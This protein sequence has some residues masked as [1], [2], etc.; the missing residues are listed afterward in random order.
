MGNAEAPAIA[1]YTLLREVGRGGMAVVWQA[2]QDSL[3][4][5]VALK[6]MSQDLAR[7]PTY[8][9][10]F[11]REGR[12]VANLRHRNILMVYDLGIADGRPYLAMEFVPGGPVAADAGRLS[13]REVLSCIRDIARALDHAHKH[14]V[15]HRDI[16]PENILRGGDGDFLL[17]DF[18]IARV[19]EATSALTMEGST[20]GTPQ[21]MSP[22]QWRGEALDGRTDLYSLGVVMYQLLTGMLPYTGTDGWAVGMQHMTSPLPAL[23]MHH[24]AFQPLLDMLLAKQP[25]DRFASGAALANAAESL[26]RTLPQTPAPRAPAAATMAMPTPVPSSAPPAPPM[27]GG[28]PRHPTP[29]PGQPVQP[30]PQPQY[31]SQ[32]QYPQHPTP[33][34]Q[35]AYGQPTPH[36]Q[37]G[38]TPHPTPHPQ[39]AQAPYQTPHPTLMRAA[40]RTGGMGTGTV[41]ALVGGGLLLVVLVIGGLVWWAA[42]QPDDN[43][44]V[45]A[46]DGTTP[47]TLTDGG[48]TLTADV[49]ATD[50]TTP[51]DGTTVDAVPPERVSPTG[52]DA[53]AAA[54]DAQVRAQ[55]DRLGLQYVVDSDNDFQLVLPTQGGR[56][57]SGWVRSV[58]ESTTQHR[59]REIWS[60]GYHAPQGQVFDGTLA[61]RLLEDAHRH[62]LGGWVR[63]GSQAMFVVKLSANATDE[64]LEEAIRLAFISA[65]TF[66]KEMTGDEDAL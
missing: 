26:L 25:G 29:W 2:T 48:D 30:A 8:A 19:R 51:D 63:Q 4:R 50:T 6:V 20:L 14:G 32:P 35:H 33:L 10:R 49:P 57:Q 17:A 37:A 24:A 44:V 15:V 55:L 41:L 16:K 7:D 36:P 28:Q 45:D 61:N 53:P 38:Y 66:E 43:T 12:V 3:N 31:P 58:V 11:L 52:T 22:E 34:P 47:A 42:S 27:S 56:T 9:E 13:Q 65:D 23:P 5:E 62:K 1:G 54:A 46:G 40:P 39:Y 60:P 18:G 59:V 64:Q 21:Y